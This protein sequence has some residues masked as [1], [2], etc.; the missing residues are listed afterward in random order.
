MDAALLAKL[1][2]GDYDGLR[3]LILERVAES[4]AQAGLLAPIDCLSGAA[5]AVRAPSLHF[6]EHDLAVAGDNKID[7]TGGAAPVL[8]EHLVARFAIPP[9][10]P[11]LSPSA[12]CLPRPVHLRAAITGPPPW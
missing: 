8:I 10:Y 9:R 5:E 1:D 7:L 11:A 2:A 12:S 6:T 4:R 3:A